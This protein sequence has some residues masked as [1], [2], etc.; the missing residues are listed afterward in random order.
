MDNNLARAVDNF[1]KFLEKI[2]T[3]PPEGFSLDDIN[4]VMKDYNIIRTAVATVMK[5]KEPLG[6]E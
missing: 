4:Q 5:D 3:N 6:K 1:E 2:I